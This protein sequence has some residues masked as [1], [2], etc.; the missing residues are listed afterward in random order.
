MSSTSPKAGGFDDGFGAV[1]S[2][3]ASKLAALM[4][5]LV[6]SALLLLHL[7]NW[8]PPRLLHWRIAR[9]VAYV[10]Y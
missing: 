10:L 2:V 9:V 4:T 6:L 8:C 5:A 7:Q 3:T 1:S